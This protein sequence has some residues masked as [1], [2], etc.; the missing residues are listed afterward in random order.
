[1]LAIQIGDIYIYFLEIF[2]LSQIYLFLRQIFKLPL[3]EF[4]IVMNI[5][6][7]DDFR[8]LGHQLLSTHFKQSVDMG[9]LGRVEILPVSWHKVCICLH[10]LLKS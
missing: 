10:L 8:K 2:L 5:F 6:S 9:L 4:F 1:M 3:I 7:V